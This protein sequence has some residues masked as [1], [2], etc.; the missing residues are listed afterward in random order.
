MTVVKC[1]NRFP[2]EAVEFPSLEKL[3]TSLDMTLSNQI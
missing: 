3:R 1:W 2:R